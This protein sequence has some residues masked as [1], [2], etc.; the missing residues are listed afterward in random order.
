MPARKLTVMLFLV[1]GLQLL[2]GAV[3]IIA[4]HL[5]LIECSENLLI[6]SLGLVFLSGLLQMIGTLFV[7]KRKDRSYAENIKNLE[8]LNIR[9]REQ[10]HDYLNQIQIVHGLL[11]LEEYESAREYLQ[12]V[13]KDI[14]K[15]NRALRTVHPAVNALLQAKMEEAERQKIDFYLEVST[16]LKQ[17]PLEPWEFCKILA[18]LIDNAITAV[19]RKQSA[20]EE[21]KN[22]DD[23]NR[24]AVRPTETEK[25]I[26][27][28]MEERSDGYHIIIENNGPEI[29][30]QQQKL[31]FNRGF[32]TKKGEGHGQGLAI[33]SSIIKEVNGSIT[34][35][36]SG[37]ST[38]FSVRIPKN[39]PKTDRKRDIVKNAVTVKRKK[40]TG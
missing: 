2:L 22:S 14:I 40:T 39:M 3:I 15:V 6:L 27:L 23:E 18:N 31:I 16:Q 11:E 29:P 36:S 10:R 28:R 8:N 24:I 30:K 25:W 12:P 34:V 38:S 17:L 33:V 19:I 35:E 5:E 4:L 9:L 7:Y 13:F 26:R 1:N 32:T 20:S 37:E 21:I